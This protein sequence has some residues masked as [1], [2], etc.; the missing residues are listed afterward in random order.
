MVGKDQSPEWKKWL[1][2]RVPQPAV[3][4]KQK[5]TKTLRNF[6]RF[7]K[8]SIRKAEVYAQHEFGAG[9]RKVRKL[10]KTIFGLG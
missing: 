8:A 6:D 9:A 10:G 1:T 7:S 4:T 2:I 5:I 3:G